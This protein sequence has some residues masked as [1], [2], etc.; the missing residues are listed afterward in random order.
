MTRIKPGGKSESRP[1]VSDGLRPH[2]KSTLHFDPDVV[3]HPA[4]ACPQLVRALEFVTHVM[5]RGSSP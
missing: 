2:G 4:E 3:G 5:R 1:Q